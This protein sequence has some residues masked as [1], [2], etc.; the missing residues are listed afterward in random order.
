MFLSENT[1]SFF[2]STSLLP[3]LLVYLNEIIPYGRVK[4]YTMINEIVL[5]WAAVLKGIDEKAKNV[6]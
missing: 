3:F 6:V 2:E 4:V 5:I 1:E